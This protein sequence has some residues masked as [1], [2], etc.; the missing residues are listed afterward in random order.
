MRSP[1][2]TSE[3]ASWTG[4]NDVDK[5]TSSS[6]GKTPVS[7]SRTDAGVIVHRNASRHL[8]QVTSVAG[9]PRTQTAVLAVAADLAQTG[10]GRASATI[11]SLEPNA[12]RNA[13]AEFMNIDERK[14][15]RVS[16]YTT[17]TRILL[18]M[19]CRGRPPPRAPALTGLLRW[20][21]ATTRREVV[22]ETRNPRLPPRISNSNL[23]ISQCHSKIERM[24]F[25]LFLI[26]RDDLIL[27]DPW[28]ENA[29]LFDRSGF[30]GL[31]RAEQRFAT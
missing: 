1:F 14:H 24:P 29:D 31:E 5:F 15:K 28:T 11:H 12:G 16:P 25:G 4:C 21:A 18:R 26:D 20:G 17:P 19:R 22:L 3:P 13:G 9:S 8:R 27:I 7:R 6:D 10:P 30:C 2:G 23:N